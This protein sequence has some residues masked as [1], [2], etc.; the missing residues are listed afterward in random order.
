MKTDPGCAKE[1]FLLEGK[2]A[3]QATNITVLPKS[4]DFKPCL[5]LINIIELFAEVLGVSFLLLFLPLST[6]WADFLTFDY[7]VPLES[8][9]RVPR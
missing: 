9:Q 4:R 2:T 1:N 7:F 3:F 6:P 8:W 5:Y